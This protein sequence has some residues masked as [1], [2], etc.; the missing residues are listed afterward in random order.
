LMQICGRPLEGA[1]GESVFGTANHALPSLRRLLGEK[2]LA[3]KA[4]LVCS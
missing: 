2:Y 3:A 1:E 4:G